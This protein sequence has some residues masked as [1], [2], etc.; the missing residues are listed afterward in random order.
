MKA[1]R[2][3]A[4]R[5]SPAFFLSL[6]FLGATFSVQPAS[7][8]NTVVAREFCGSTPCEEPIRTVLGI[9]A[10]GD[11]ELI[12]WKL[13]LH[14]DSA[15]QPGHYEL[16]CQYG[17][18]VPNQPG[19]GASIKT[20][21]KRGVW[22]VTKG[23]QFDPEAVVHELVGA[24]SLFQV[25]PNILQILDPDR[26]LMIGHGGWSY[27]LNSTDHSE[28]PIDPALAR[29]VPDMSYPIS[30]R[31]TGHEVLAVLE[32]RTPCQGIARELGIAVPESATK[33]KWR[34]TLYQDPQTRSP[35][36]Y[37]IEGTLFRKAAREGSWS[38]IRGAHGKPDAIVYQ[39]RAGK[40]EPPLHLLKGDDN[41]LFFLGQAR[42][43]LV[44]NC[45]FSYTLNRRSRHPS[46][47][48]SP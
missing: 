40:S 30:A 5:F 1:L 9:P 27:T 42:N 21:E 3:A 26:S 37:K 35:T 16:R 34:V 10:D 13:T 43:H 14:S 28:K 25:T 38:I 7:L 46:K 23:T 31:S 29:T 6:I 33:A 45:E 20:I 18:T 41:V 48:S 36:T 15:Q 8:R 44:G 19:L 2:S 4:A 17:R 11:P 32:G 39:L 12:Q 47:V 22:K 24:A